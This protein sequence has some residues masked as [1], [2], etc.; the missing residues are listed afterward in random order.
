M[1]LGQ[2]MDMSQRT[3]LYRLFNTSDVLLYVGIAF[4]PKNRWY[5]H[6]STKSWWP[7]VAR[8]EV[9]WHANRPTALAA[10]RRA[11]VAERPLYNIVLSV[12][13]MR[14]PT[15]TKPTKPAATR[16]APRSARN[17][18]AAIRTF[19]RAAAKVER[20]RAELEDEIRRAIAT[21]EWQIIHVVTVTGWSRETIRKIARPATSRPA[22]A[23]D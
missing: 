16:S 20:A 21:E 14:A 3:A 13:P 10:E 7:E 23:E 22:A 2:R 19:E 18:V 9:E 17:P 8:K 5:E 12:D 15:R 6:A 11:I 4:D 1:P